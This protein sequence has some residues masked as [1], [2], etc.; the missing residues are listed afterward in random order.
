MQAPPESHRRCRPTRALSGE[1]AH[2][3]CGS[4]GSKLVLPS[5]AQ[6]VGVHAAEDCGFGHGFGKLLQGRYPA[7]GSNSVF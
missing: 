5:R 3:A 2:S 1:R 4:E 6:Y 7:R